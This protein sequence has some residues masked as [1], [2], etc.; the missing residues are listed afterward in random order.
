MDDKQLEAVILAVLQREKVD[1]TKTQS[2]TEAILR[3]MKMH[4]AG[5]P[6]SRCGGSGIE[7]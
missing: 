4:L 2:L 3:E 7:R 1:S 5:T 6:C